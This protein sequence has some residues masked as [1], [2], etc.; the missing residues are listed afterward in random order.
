M[1]LPTPLLVRAQHL[2]T[3]CRRFFPSLVLLYVD[4]QLYIRRTDGLLGVA[5]EADKLAET[6]RRET[7]SNALCDGRILSREI[8]VFFLSGLAIERGKIN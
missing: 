5:I 1:L 3:L 6:Y 7:D 4:G 2:H 8:C